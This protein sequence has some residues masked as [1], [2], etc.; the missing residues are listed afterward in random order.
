M[1]E[2]IKIH[3]YYYIIIYVL[4]K[5]DFSKKFSNFLA[6]SKRTEGT[7]IVLTLFLAGSIVSI[8]TLAEYAQATTFIKP[9]TTLI[10]PRDTGQED[11]GQEDTAVNDTEPSQEAVMDSDKILDGLINYEA[12]IFVWDKVV[13]KKGQMVS[14]EIKQTPIN[15]PDGG[16]EDNKAIM[17]SRGDWMTSDKGSEFVNNAE[18]K[19]F[20]ITLL[21]NGEEKG[22]A[23]GLLLPGEGWGCSMWC[24][25]AMPGQTT[26]NP[27][28][29]GEF[30]CYFKT[31]LQE[32]GG[33]QVL[34][35]MLHPEH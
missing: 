34:W 4:N 5:R 18:G 28:A 21:A 30:N 29:V 22:K 16:V 11:T 26:T 17:V 15:L 19:S 7:M 31:V 25:D 14:E 2:L 27:D 9:Q 20:E 8:P 32:N 33:V 23:S 24:R 35:T 12:P 10:P 3:K 6:K 13:L 1:P